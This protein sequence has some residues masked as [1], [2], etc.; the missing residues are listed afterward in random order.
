MIQRTPSPDF[1][2]ASSESQPEELLCPKNPTPPEVSTEVTTTALRATRRNPSGSS[3]SDPKSDDW[4]IQRVLESEDCIAPDPLLKAPPKNYQYV[5]GNGYLKDKN[6]YANRAAAEKKMAARLRG[7]EGD[8]PQYT[9]PHPKFEAHRKRGTATPMMHLYYG[10]LPA[11]QNLPLAGIP[12]DEAKTKLSEKPKPNHTKSKS[13]TKDSDK[14]LFPNLVK[15][16]P[17]PEPK[18]AAETE[19]EK[20]YEN[21]VS[22][23]T[24]ATASMGDLTLNQEENFHSRPSIKLVIPDHI[25]AI[26]VDD[27]ENV[28]K[29]AQLVPLPSAQP[30]SSILADYY[31]YEKPKR[32]PGSPQ[33]D[34]LEEV[35]S[36][37][38]EYFEKCLGRLLL[39]R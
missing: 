23:F 32:L 33:A 13:V 36:G 30:V 19:K 38:K 12:R 15:P 9:K 2:S 10:G 5:D 8:E 18:P 4:D 3:W 1:G 25:K 17:A 7:D 21:V 22:R 6:K 28:T 14:A 11:D 29:N 37:L 39:Y 16:K 20:Q 24:R 31:E 27:W 35:V 34:I 26:L